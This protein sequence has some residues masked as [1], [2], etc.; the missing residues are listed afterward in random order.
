MPAP[1]TGFQGPFWRVFPWDASARP[2]DPYSPQYVLPAGA[3]TGGRFDLADTP[4]LY[5]AL[6]T[7]TRQ[8]RPVSL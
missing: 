7:V 4:T 3:Q 2:G 8:V 1:G 5:I 6:G